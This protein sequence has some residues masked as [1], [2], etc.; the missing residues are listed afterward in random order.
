MRKETHLN[1]GIPCIYTHF[2]LF[3][4]ETSKN[5][6]KKQSKAE[7]DKAKKQVEKAVLSTNSGIDNESDEDVS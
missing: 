1:H 6:P 4:K 7:K 2:L 3:Q 5:K